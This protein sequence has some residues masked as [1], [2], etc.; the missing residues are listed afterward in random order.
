MPFV[1][2]P[3]LTPPPMIDSQPPLFGLNFVN[4]AE[5]PVKLNGNRASLN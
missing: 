2:L 3:C 4:I 5:R 1:L